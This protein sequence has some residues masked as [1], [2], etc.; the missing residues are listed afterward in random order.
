MAIGENLMIDGMSPWLMRRKAAAEGHVVVSSVI[1]QP[2]GP[3]GTRGFMMGH[4]G[5]LVRVN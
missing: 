4:R 5:S 1:R 2:R 3:D